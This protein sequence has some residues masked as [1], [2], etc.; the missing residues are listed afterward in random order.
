MRDVHL[1]WEISTSG[2]LA[3]LRE[4]DGVSPS[5]CHRLRSEQQPLF[6]ARNVTFFFSELIRSGR[7]RDARGKARALPARA[8]LC[9]G[10][11]HFQSDSKTLTLLRAR[12]RAVYSLSASAR[13]QLQLHHVTS[14]PRGEARAKMKQKKMSSDERGE[15]RLAASDTEQRAD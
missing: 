12:G 9:G 14:C 5:R 15:T 1:L 11:C 13:I 6:D 7:S 2:P 10:R 8:A 4:C 3:T